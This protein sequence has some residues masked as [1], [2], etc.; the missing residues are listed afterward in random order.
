[1][2]VHVYI[3]RGLRCCLFSYQ[4]NTRASIRGTAILQ[5][6]FLFVCFVWDIFV[7]SINGVSRKSDKE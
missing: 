5:S 6:R 4:G 2:C 3:R 7:K 1:M